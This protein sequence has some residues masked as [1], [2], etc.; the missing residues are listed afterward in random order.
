QVSIHDNFFVLGGHSLLTMQI[1]SRLY[2]ALQVNLPLRSFFDAPTVA[3]LTELIMQKQAN[4]LP[5]P[6]L[7]LQQYSKQSQLEDTHIFPTSSA[8]QALWFIHQL[9]TSNTAYNLPVTLFIHKALHIE[10]LK[11]SLDILVQRHEAL[12]TTF[13]VV[14]EQPVQLVASQMNIPITIKDLQHVPPAEQA[15]T[16]MHLA[17]QELQRPF[18]LRQGPLIRACVLQLA[19]EENILLLVM[20]H[21]IS[22]GWSINLLL[23]EFVRL[24]EAHQNGGG[25]SVPGLDLQFGSFA[26]WQREWLQSEMFSEHLSY[27]MEH[28]AGAPTT[29]TLPTDH[30]RPI[31]STFKGAMHTFA[32]SP[33]LSSAIKTLSLQENVTLYMTLVAAFLTLL[34]R[35]SG[36]D[37][38]L[39]GT[40]MAGRTLAETQPLV[41]YIINTVVLRTD[42]SGNPTVRD[43]LGRVRE[44]VL[45]ADAHQHLPF[46]IL[47]RELQPDRSQKQS[48]LFQVFLT[49]D[50]PLPE[51]EPGYD[52]TQL[53]LATGASKFDLSLELADC[54]G[55]IIGHLEYSTDL[56]NAS[57]IARM[58]AHWET[59]LHAMTVD[60]TR[61]LSTLP[62]LTNAE[63]QQILFDWNDTHA[64]YS[65]T[66]T[67]PQ[68]FEAQVKRTPHV[69]AITFNDASLSYRKLNKAANQF[70]HYL[71]ERGIKPG[72]RI[73]LCYE[74]SHELIIALLGILKAGGT[75][76]PLDP[77][78]PPERLAF[79]LTD[80][81]AN[82]LVTQQHL[83]AHL[84][85]L[86]SIDNVIC[87]DREW[88]TIR[89]GSS[90]NLGISGSGEDPAYMLYT[91]GSTGTP[92]GVLGTHRAAINR[93]NWM[94]RTYPFADGE[95]CCQKTTLSF[96]DSVW[97]IFGPLLQGIQTVIIPDAV[98]KDP[99]Q[100][101][102]VLAVHSVTRIVLVPSLLRVLLDS[103][104][105]LKERWP[106]LKYCICS[107][108]ALPLELARRFQQQ[109]PDCLLLNLYG[110][111]EV[112]ADVTCYEIKG[113]TRLSCVPIGH[114]IDN[115]QI[116]LLDRNMQLVPIGV[117]GELYVG[118]DGLALGYFNRPEL[119]ATK[120]VRHPFSERPEALLY[121]T[122]DLARYLP[123]GTIE[124]LGRLDHQVKIRGMRIELG[125]IESALRQHP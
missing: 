67:L 83:L 125:E 99:Q 119:T 113:T 72:A 80:S 16:I 23:Q 87:L 123:D 31:Q 40:T 30:P 64:A 108:E 111:S 27:W 18:D 97:E 74:R 52:A 49:L 56:F 88:Q 121:K 20:H 73:A 36:Q 48:P 21:S 63:Q 103:E 14:D 22:D 43:L 13:A 102:K 53:D 109:M 112:A 51:L 55:G 66:A 110:S 92:K 58:A 39:L 82:A 8:Q 65:R 37:D 5:E 42:L 57:T 7:V 29:L 26:T 2:A 70:A 117:P 11:Q 17:T 61:P 1:A 6:Q 62:L 122:G 93:F 94:W 96:V 71:Q 105:A 38:L 104:T 59:L 78:Y 79:M 85:Q 115:T 118:G 106:A 114:P 28:L 4:G 46:D 9:D 60:P 50:P 44:V 98:V 47:V 77:A 35:Y 91:S 116:Y 75:Y 84:P 33:E 54:P 81:Q 86:A 15:P 95:V 124:Y 25:L 107:G 3:Q 12:R 100:F 34:Q 32:L 41:G 24:Y 68:L 120:F 10:T 45:A 19:P 76:V 89:K 69:Q 90:K 101:L